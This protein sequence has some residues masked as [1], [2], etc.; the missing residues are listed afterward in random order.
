MW[1][2]SDGTIGVGANKD[3]PRTNRFHNAQTVRVCVEEG[4]GDERPTNKGKG[5]TQLVYL[6]NVHLCPSECVCARACVY[7]LKA[8]S[9]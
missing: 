1:F 2:S 5:W 7:A 9:D 3:K 4:I 8:A 6:M